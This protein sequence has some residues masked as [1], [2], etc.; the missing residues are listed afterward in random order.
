VRIIGKYSAKTELTRS[1]EIHGS[2]VR[3]NYVFELNVLRYGP[4]PQEGSADAGDERE[5]KK[6]VLVL[7]LE[8]YT[9]RT[10]QHNC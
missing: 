1:R 5:K 2:N 9:S 8:C 10:K 7:V 3:L 6:V 4:Y